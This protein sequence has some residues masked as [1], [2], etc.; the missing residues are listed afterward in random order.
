MQNWNAGGRVIKSLTILLTAGAVVPLVA[1]TSGDW[2]MY[3][4]DLAATRYS[5]LSQIS[6]QN[7]A[8]LAPAWTF[9]LNA[10]GMEVTPLVVNGS[11]YLTA[12]K[13]VVALEPETGK[14][15]WSYE[16]ATGN[17]ATRGLA[18]WPGD[19]EHAPRIVFTAGRRMLALNAK[20]GKIDPGFG[21]EGEVDLV[22]GYNAPPTVYKNLLFV[23]ANAPEQPATGV[24]GDTRAYDARTGAKVWE[25]HSVP[26]AGEAGNETWEGDAWK[27]RTGVNNWGFFMTVDAERGILYTVFGSPASDYY[28]ADRKGDNLFGNSVVALDAETGKLKWYFQAVHHDLWD[29]DL[30]PAPVLADVRIN[31]RMTPVLAQ[32]GKVGY[33]YILNRVT[34]KPVLGIEE[35]PVPQSQVP[36]EHTSATQPIPR[37][38][39]ELARHSFKLDDLVTADDTTPEHAQAC[40]D[41]VEKSGALYNEGPFTPWVFRGP[42][43]PPRSSIIFPGA[44][45]GNDWGGMSLDPKLGYV[46]VNTSEFGSMGWIEKLPDGSRVPYDQRSVYGNPV[47]S[48]FWERKLDANG[49]VRGEDSWPCQKPPWGRLTAID[50]KTGEFAWQVPLGITDELPEGK[51]NTGRVNQ[52]GSIATAG[53]VVFIGAS[54]DRRFRAFDSKTGRELWAVKL[55]YS[56]ISVPITYVGKN[57][58]QYVAISAGGHNPVTTPNPANTESLYVFALP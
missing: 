50:L 1:Q 40:R 45:G 4:H 10:R 26:R 52:G 8:R 39:P 22:V 47:A 2:P 15:T 7:V 6:T 37:K 55:D 25:F 24:P 53:G 21:K 30:P 14:E 51:R 5:P 18:Y 16:L 19:R 3:S 42:G 31:G 38:P 34:G 32:T 17:A 43:V 44:I 46:F 12:G 20:T 48:K 28:G 33:L 27:D 23:G 58:K 35:K 56:A 41:L 11:M 54:N 49:A 29:F 13:R 57:G 36:G 9:R